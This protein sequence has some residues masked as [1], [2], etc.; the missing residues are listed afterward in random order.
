MRSITKL[1]AR[2]ALAF[3]ALTVFTAPALAAVPSN[4][5]FANAKPVTLGFS[6][7]V[8]TTKARTEALDAQALQECGAPAVSATVW[9]AIQGDGSRV[10]VD[11][12]GTSYVPGFAVV[13]GS[14]GNFTFVTCDAYY[15]AFDSVAGATYYVMA[16]D[17]QEDGLG[18][19]GSLQIAFNR[20]VLPKL[21]FSVNSNGTLDSSSGSATISGSYSCSTE[22]PG[23]EF[24][25][26]VDAKQGK[27]TGRGEFTGPC[28]GTTH[29]W[30]AVVAPEGGQFT[31]G[32]LQTSSFGVASNVDQGI[33]NE[34]KQNVNLP[35]AR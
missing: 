4:D 23:N 25:V 7:T 14:P 32:K 20:S 17:G 19:G 22:T 10:L 34:I 26:F 29:S 13:T 18:K 33:A 24:T 6:E 16:F 2:L 30:A 5:R 8:D 28:D 3:V 12:R 11:L 31:S 27:L 1:L 35:R 21:T 9:Y 15:G